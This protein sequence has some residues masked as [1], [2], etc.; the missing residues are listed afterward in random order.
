MDI[1]NAINTFYDRNQNNRNE[2]YYLRVKG[3]GKNKYLVATRTPKG[4]FGRLWMKMG[5][6]NASMEKVINLLNKKKVLTGIDKINPQAKDFFLSKLRLYK[7]NHKKNKKLEKKINDVVTKL[8]PV[9]KQKPAPPATPAAKQPPPAEETEP[10]DRNAGQ[11]GPKAKQTPEPTKPPGKT[12]SKVETPED[13]LT[14]SDTSSSSSS[15]EPASSLSKEQVTPGGEEDDLDMHFWETIHGV[16]DKEPEQLM[17]FNS[18][19]EAQVPLENKADQIFINYAKYI[20][21]DGKL[22]GNEKTL[23]KLILEGLKN[24]EDP[25]KY[26][27]PLDK[28]YNLRILPAVA[29]GDCAF[30]SLLGKV[31]DGEYRCNSKQAREQFHDWLKQQFELK[32][33]P[34]YLDNELED[35][36]LNF[37]GALSNI[38]KSMRKIYDHYRKGYD[39]LPLERQEGRKNRFKRHPVVIKAYLDNLKIPSTYLSQSELEALGKCFNKEI[40]L[41]SRVGK[42]VAPQ[43]YNEKGGERVYLWYNGE[44]DKIRPANHFDRVQIETIQSS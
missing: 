35:V 6:S 8:S 5:F 22:K 33:I 27:I 7:D 17:M 13:D 9:P 11:I 36:F 24:S 41:Y 16:N 21:K 3:K 10:I 23:K 1:N 28:D 26:I 30:H 14:E 42:D 40:V 2:K 12:K 38:Q 31:Q 4:R 20:Q 25:N 39:D 37:A 44:N 32:P 19:I 18:I 43:I 29:D 34:D 15:L